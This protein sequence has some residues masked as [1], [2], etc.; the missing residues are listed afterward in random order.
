VHKQKQVSS[1]LVVAVDR[2][3][4]KK[5]KKFNFFERV[6]KRS[7][8]SENDIHMYLRLL[9]KYDAKLSSQK[10]VMGVQSR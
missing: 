5:K 10:K 2:W 6:Q 7:K 1:K 4:S 3:C 9:P 8:L